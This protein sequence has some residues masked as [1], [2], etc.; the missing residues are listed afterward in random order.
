MIIMLIY[1]KICMIFHQVMSSLIQSL[2]YYHS[3]TKN[4]SPK[5][6]TFFHNLK[7]KIS[8]TTNNKLYTKLRPRESSL[9]RKFS[10]A[11]SSF[12]NDYI[13]YTERPSIVRI[14]EHSQ[15]GSHVNKVHFSF[16]ECSVP[17]SPDGITII[18]RGN[19]RRDL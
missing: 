10:E 11:S 16:N 15:K 18:A 13:G 4:L 2:Y 17:V 19:F 14:S 5:F 12:E 1:L 9:R 3:L 7:I 6:K 8:F